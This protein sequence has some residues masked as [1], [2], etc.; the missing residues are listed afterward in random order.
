MKGDDEIKLIENGNVSKPMTAKEVSQFLAPPIVRTPKAAGTVDDYIKK[1]SDRT[2]LMTGLYRRVLLLIETVGGNKDVAF[3]ITG[4][5]LLITFILIALS[6]K[7]NLN[8]DLILQV[9]YLLVSGTGSVAA[10]VANLHAE[11]GNL[12]TSLITKA[13]EIE[14]PKKV[15]RLDALGRTIVEKK[16]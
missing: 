10:F 11:P 5:L 6:G 4:I 2:L 8:F 9:L 3:L 7:Y 16:K 14:D 12:K 13:K 1:D 15:M